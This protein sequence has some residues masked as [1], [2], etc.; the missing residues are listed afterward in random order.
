MSSQW[1]LYL[2]LVTRL[3]CW[4]SLSRKLRFHKSRLD[5][6][7]IIMFV[8][9]QKLS[10]NQSVKF[11]GETF[12][13]A[14]CVWVF[15]PPGFNLPRTKGQSFTWFTHSLPHFSREINFQATAAFKIRWVII[16]KDVIFHANDIDSKHMLSP[17][18]NQTLKF[19]LKGRKI[20]L[21]S[22]D[23]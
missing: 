16:R 6:I 3:S 10:V 9:C 14:S 15:E 22:Q 18:C 1:S 8:L 21:E 12:F 2:C 11:C 23:L 19:N 7:K 13:S 4:T 20:D 5:R 17:I